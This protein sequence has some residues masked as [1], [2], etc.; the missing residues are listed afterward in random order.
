VYLA[1]ADALA[2]DLEAER[3]RP[4]E[5]LPTHRE[6]A[7]ILGVNVVT[8]TRAYAEAARRGLVDGH[9]GRG[10]FVRAIEERPRNRPQR[11]SASGA[12]DLSQNQIALEIGSLDA[13]ALIAALGSR[14]EAALH[15]GYQPAGQGEHRDAG[16]QWLARAG[17]AVDPTRVMVTTGGQQ[18]LAAVFATFAKAGDTVLVEELTYAGVK[19]LAALFR[20]RLQPVALDEQGLVPEALEEACRRGNPKLLYCMPNLHNPTGVVLP[21]ERRER[22]ARLAERYDL[23]ILEDD[24]SGFLLEAPPPPIAALVP[25]RGLFVT[26]LSKSLAPG[27]R[28]GYLA[29]PEK[30]LEKLHQTQAALTWMT[31][32]LT[33]AIASSLIQSGELARVADRKRAEIRRRR[34]LF[35]QALGHLA[36]PSHGA[37]PCVW[38]T[39]PEPWRGE[40]FVAAAE[41]AGVLVSAAETF[42]VSRAHTPHA[43]RLCLGTPASRAEVEN[44]LTRLARLLEGVPV[45]CRALV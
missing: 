23:L 18:A 10:T 38:I 11:G 29:A 16:A 21:P 9:V 32:A 30:E 37:S 44:A 6:L 19:S 2:A 13:A 15:S 39:L 27:L 26:S 40:E 43:A 34:A 45:P 14:F 12:I 35:Q 5:R 31:P 20:L 36:S 4:G 22:V 1:I 7:R 41:R 17:L 33:A 42:V 8:I 28:V 24:A 3:I 25:E